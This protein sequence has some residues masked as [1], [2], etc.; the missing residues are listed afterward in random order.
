M[1]FNKPQLGADRY[2]LNLLEAASKDP[3]L[4]VPLESWVDE[5]SY[6]LEQRLPKDL[7]KELNAIGEHE[8]IGR[9]RRRHRGQTLVGNNP[10][11]EPF[12]VNLAAWLREG[13]PKSA[14]PRGPIATNLAHSKVLFELPK[15]QCRLL[16]LMVTL[17]KDNAL[18]EIAGRLARFLD[19]ST[20][21][22][23]ILAGI[24]A[25]RAKAALHG[26]KDGLIAVGL[27]TSP[28]YPTRDDLPFALSK[29][30]ATA[31]SNEERTL[32]GFRAVV[33]GKPA[34][35]S[36][37]LKAF[38]HMHKDVDLLKRLLEGGINEEA[39]RLNILLE[40]PAGAGKTEL[41]KTVG[42]KIGAN[43]YSVG[44]T[45]DSG[46][47]PDASE[48][49]ASLMMAERILSRAGNAIIVF[50][51]AEDLI[52]DQ[53]FGM[54][55]A[56]TFDS[57]IFVNRMME[58]NRV[59]IIWIANKAWFFDQAFHRR[60]KY[61]I[62]FKL[63]ETKVRAK[64]LKQ[65][66]KANDLEL[67]KKD[68][69][70]IAAEFEVPPALLAN[71]AEAASLSKGDIDDIRHVLQ[72]AANA[73]GFRRVPPGER[74]ALDRP[75]FDEQLICF[76]GG[77]KPANEVIANILGAGRLDISLLLSGPPGTGKTF[78]VQHLASQMGLKL[79]KKRASDIL[80]PF[81]AMTEKHICWAFEDAADE[82]AFLF[83]DEVDSLLID[84]RGA[85]RAY[86]VS[87]TNEL[88]Q[89]MQDH[90]FPFA[91]AT[92]FPESLDTAA[93]RR[94]TFKVELDFF[95]P[96]QVERAWKVFFG[97]EAPIEARNMEL[98]TA[99]DFATVRKKADVIGGLE[100]PARLMRYL[101]DETAIKEG[102]HLVPRA[103]G[104]GR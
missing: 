86:E 53:M 73:C 83:F 92:N 17:T 29:R 55:A 6:V 27:F 62:S 71:A 41:A 102:T 32:E 13:T 33:L 99:G 97:L 82:E 58:S 101:A 72:K 8:G 34:K 54:G 75:A 19:S 78:L 15:D 69:F 94:F 56:R 49:L 22:L 10:E 3:Q 103:V 35:A 100:D 43:V 52:T 28:E 16:A 40:G 47:A 18:A 38:D 70:A 48:R 12:F 74:D 1:L 76:K 51:E 89:H 90:P 80:S 81:H 30:I 64:I 66:A 39:K 36:M 84:R 45:D 31:I 93:F 85:H 88:L 24:S 77:E 37:R 42:K 60:N 87:Q 14:A 57:K 96:A 50:D 104:F 98:L 65:A 67:S 11:F 5:N 79:M 20:K 63:P 26:Q 91:C 7:A 25:K 44:E 61:T 68:A 95:G 23:A 21:T 46:E 2:F 59:P 4:Y 9:R